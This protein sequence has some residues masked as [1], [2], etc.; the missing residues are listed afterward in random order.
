MKALRLWIKGL[1][2]AGIGGAATAV[3]T[4][5]AAPETFNFTD[6]KNKLAAVAAVSAIVAVANYLKASPIPSEDCPK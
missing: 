4:M 1:I 2:S 3:S 6:G 5:I